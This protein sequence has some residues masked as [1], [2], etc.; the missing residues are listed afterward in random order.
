MV[1]YLYI[2]TKNCN[3]IYS[4]WQTSYTLRPILAILE[5]H[6]REKNIVMCTYNIDVRNALKMQNIEVVKQF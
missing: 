1:T 4:V 2:Y 5:R 3:N 6:S